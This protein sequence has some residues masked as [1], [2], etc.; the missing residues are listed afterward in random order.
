MYRYLI[1]ILATLF[2]VSN[3]CADGII[4]QTHLYAVK[5]ADSLYLDHY[6]APV[7]GKRPCMMFVFGGG[8]VGGQRD[9]KL[10]SRYFQFLTEQGFDVVSID[11][12]LGLKNLGKNTAGSSIRDMI[13][14]INNAI[15]IAVED[16]FSATLFVIDNAERWQIDTDNIVTSGSSAG[17]ITVLQAE[18]NICNRTARA[19]VL[20]AGF[21]YAGIISFAGAIFSTS[22]NPEWNNQPAPT[23]MFHGS[24]DRQVPYEKATMLR[25]GFYGSKFLSDEFTKQGWPHWFY[26]IN[27]DSHNVAGT[28]MFENLNEIATFLK[29]FAL[30]R[31]PLTIKTDETDGELP[32]CKTKFK[33]MDYIEANYGK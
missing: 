12:R 17:A 27:Y 18:Q 9:N 32:K 14:V 10:Y 24:A 29:E 20:P 4:A 2:F 30:A 22:G 1:T 15:N 3:V 11:Y 31:R 23:M 26:S 5:G 13:G 21:N 8:F 16:L 6:I 7:E 33:I 25:V 19:A 28:P